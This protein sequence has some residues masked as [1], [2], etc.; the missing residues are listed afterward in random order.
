MSTPQKVIIIGAGYG[1]MALANL[2][3][4]RGDQ[5]HVY[6]KNAE[7]GGRIHAIRQD[8]FLFDL[9]PSWY[10]MPEVFDQYY[11]LFGESA[12][13]RLDLLRLEI[14]DEPREQVLG[15]DDLDPHFVLLRAGGE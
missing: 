14:F 13:D 7:L 1:G 15:I 4:K 5:V 6:E 12:Q 2:L 8:G 10:L 11:D 3:A 9:G